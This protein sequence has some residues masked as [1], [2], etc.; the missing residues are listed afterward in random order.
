MN[1][2]FGGIN[3]ATSVEPK[4]KEKL[5]LKVQSAEEH[6]IFG[7]CMSL[8]CNLGASNITVSA[9]MI[10][11]ER[12]INLSLFSYIPIVQENVDES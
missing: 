4:E 8:K 5:L 1:T 3:A 10:L 6:R 9:F 2:S 11:I 12:T 7:H